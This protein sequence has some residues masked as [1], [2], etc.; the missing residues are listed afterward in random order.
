MSTR[1]T[2][3]EMVQMSAEAKQPID[4]FV[5]TAQIL[6]AHALKQQGLRRATPEE[7]ETLAKYLEGLAAGGHLSSDLPSVDVLEG[8]GVR[9]VQG[10]TSYATREL[11]RILL[12]A[13]S[14]KAI[15][16]AA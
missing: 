15:R 8:A 11:K 9:K 14:N 3:S 10:T 4:Q 13:N 7:K 5:R 12:I 1:Y 2:M 16:A 6:E